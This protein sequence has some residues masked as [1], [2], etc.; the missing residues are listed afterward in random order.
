LARTRPVVYECA[1]E[2]KIY[3]FT[4]LKF[5]AKGRRV[6]RNT[7]VILV[8]FFCPVKALF[9]YEKIPLQAYLEFLGRFLGARP[10][11]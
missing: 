4:G 3:C 7:Q 11:S 10:L 2:L 6:I 1:K 5:V 8:Y 9:L